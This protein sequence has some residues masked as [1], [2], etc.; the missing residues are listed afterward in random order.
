[1]VVGGR[2]LFGAYDAHLHL[3][4]AASGRLLSKTKMPGRVLSSPC[5]VK[6][7]V[8]IGTATGWFYCLG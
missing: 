7:H 1:V 2:V 3:L 5:V 4:D 6:G 8:W